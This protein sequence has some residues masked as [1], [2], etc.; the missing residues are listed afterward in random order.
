MSD[1]S[2]QRRRATH[3]QTVRQ[4][5]FGRSPQLFDQMALVLA[6]P[7]EAQKLYDL[8][9]A[10]DEFLA[11]SPVAITAY[12]S[13]ACPGFREY[14]PFRQHAPFWPQ[15]PDGTKAVSG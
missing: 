9:P 13:D 8:L 10:D 12:V 6:L 2:S 15:S 7:H 1:T 5:G 4:F 3:T 14:Q 11:V